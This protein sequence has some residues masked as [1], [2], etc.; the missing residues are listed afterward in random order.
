[1]NRDELFEHIFEIKLLCN[2]IHVFTVKLS[3][4]NLKLLNG[5][6]IVGHK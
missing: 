2:T 6:V 4:Q 3:P 1:M 5:V